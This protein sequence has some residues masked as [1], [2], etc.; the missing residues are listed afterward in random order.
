MLVVNPAVSPLVKQRFRAP[1]FVEVSHAGAKRG[2]NSPAC[3][4][5]VTAEVTGRYCAPMSNRVY[6]MCGRTMK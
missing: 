4:F 3:L 5:D 6:L 2:N 1:H